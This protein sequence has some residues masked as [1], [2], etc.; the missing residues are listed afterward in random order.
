M[1]ISVIIP[2]YNSGKFL[3]KC[4]DSVFNQTYDAFEVIVADGHSTDNSP[5]IL[6]RYQKLHKNLKVIYRVSKGISDNI[7]A[8]M[9][10]ATGDVVGYLCADDT[11]EPKCLEIVAQYFKQPIVQWVYGKSKIIDSEGREIRRFVTKV[12]ELFQKRYTYI[13]LQCVDFIVQLT[14]FLRRQFYQQIGE[15]NVDLK[16]GMDYDY[17]LRAGKVSK[18]M[19]IDWYLA[20]WRA[21]SESTSEKEHVAEARQ[22]LGIQKRFSGWWFRP[23]QYGVYLLTIL[24]YW[25]VSKLK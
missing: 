15:Y 1:K 6:K 7:N 12:K 14:V 19:F 8:G 16:F 20:N 3:E 17:C 24:L 23:I 11:Y 25:V 5:Q 4:L 18:P 21:H 22:A 2:N 10:L 13:D 9:K